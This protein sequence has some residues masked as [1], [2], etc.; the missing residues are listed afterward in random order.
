MTKISNHNRRIKLMRIKCAYNI[1]INEELILL[2]EKQ[3]SL[4]IEIIIGVV[5]GYLFSD[6][7]ERVLCVET[8]HKEPIENLF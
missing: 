2:D 1:T 4:N 8:L 3:T 5:A 7:F 6:Q